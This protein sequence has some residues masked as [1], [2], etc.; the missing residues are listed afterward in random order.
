VLGELLVALGAFAALGPEVAAGAL[1]VAAAGRGSAGLASG[2]FWQPAAR[3]I[4]IK[5][6][7]L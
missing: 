7:P 1:G 5:P 6:N 4:T 3:T 2:P